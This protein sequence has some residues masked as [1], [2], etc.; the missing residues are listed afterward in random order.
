MKKRKNTATDELLGGPIIRKYSQPPRDE[1][2]VAEAMK[3]LNRISGRVDGIRKMLNEGR[4]CGDILMQL[5]AAK[6]MIHQCEYL[7]L[8]DHLKT[9]VVEQ[10]A[11]GND[12]VI[13]ELEILMKAFK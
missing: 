5:S 10:L 4:Y 1:D 13:D 9:C 7:I 2:V 11:G 6:S 3:K 12:S 8:E